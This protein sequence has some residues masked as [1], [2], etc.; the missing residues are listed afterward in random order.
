MK[1]IS[2]PPF[3][4]KVKK[5]TFTRDLTSGTGTQQITGIG[6][7]PKAVIILASKNTAY[8]SVGVDTGG[9]GGCIY[10]EGGNFYPDSSESI[11]HYVNGSDYAYGHIASLD[12]D[13]FTFQWQHVGG[14]GT[15]TMQGLALG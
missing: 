4:L 6:F 12:V 2:T 13:G 8:A 14:S 7:K 15:L 5:F 1:G 11:Y 10:T 9:A 3:S